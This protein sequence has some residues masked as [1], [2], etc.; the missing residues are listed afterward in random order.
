M[1]KEIKDRIVDVSF[2]VSSCV[3]FLCR[4]QRCDLFAIYVFVFFVFGMPTRRFPYRRKPSELVTHRI[5][6]VT[7]NQDGVERANLYLVQELG[8]TL[9]MV[10][11]EEEETVTV[12]ATTTHSLED[13]ATTTP[14]TTSTET[15]SR[16]YKVAIGDMQKCTCGDSEVC[17]HVLFVMI[18]L[19][20]VPA[21]NPLVWQH[22][23][24][25]REV[26]DILSGT[27]RRRAEARRRPPVRDFLR[28]SSTPSTVDGA[29]GCG[30]VERRAIEEGDTCPVC[31]DD[32]KPGAKDLTYCKKGCG[33]QAHAKC[34]KMYAEHNQ[35]VGKKVTCPL[36][37]T[38]WGPM[39][40][41]ELKKEVAGVSNHP[42]VL[43]CH[44]P[45][46]QQ[47]TGTNY[48]CITCARYDLCDRCFRGTAVHAQHQFVKRD[49][50]DAEWSPAPRV[51]RR[52]GPAALANSGRNGQRA[53]GLSASLL[54]Q[55]QD[56][57]SRR[58]F[59]SEDYELLLQLDSSVRTNSRRATMES[60][61]I[62]DDTTTVSMEEYLTDL[63]KQGGGTSGR[64]RS[65]SSSIPALS[66][67][68][69]TMCVECPGRM[70]NSGANISRLPCGHW[71]HESCAA[72]FVRR[73]AS[74]HYKCP[75]CDQ[76]AFPGLCRKRRRRR[77]PGA[78]ERIVETASAQTD[79]SDI[80]LVLEATGFTVTTGGG[81]S[82]G[83]EATSAGAR[84]RPSLVVPRG[85]RRHALPRRDNTG[86]AFSAPLGLTVRPASTAASVG[87]LGIPNPAPRCSRASSS[88]ALRRRRSHGLAIASQADTANPAGSASMPVL[89][90]S[91]AGR[92]AG[93]TP[94]PPALE[95]QAAGLTRI[96]FGRSMPL[97]SRKPKRENIPN[98]N[99]LALG[100]PIAKKRTRG[101][102]ITGLTFS[103]RKVG[104]TF[105]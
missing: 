22:A 19:L 28:R 1:L 81:A 14:P 97:K 64:S 66:S 56:I 58:E 98:N 96:S 3:P 11:H 36:C 62:Y 9:F 53:S 27:F 34:M 73:G 40:L 89:T 16:K 51:R 93:V 8:P 84:P 80:A 61:F 90:V 52:R 20:R 55:L 18:K 70:S 103:S 47:I 37:R 100:A 4:L 104:D 38:D 15:R 44:C 48:R 43:C 72:G 60:R 79:A 49:A 76:T 101:K 99:T 74:S 7:G 83:A 87:A 17:V 50:P 71:L 92:G 42:R 67:G 6:Q 54:S 10:R 59:S 31:L 25:D 75:T 23:L 65:S 30:G 63:L 85:D 102:R 57:Q 45:S 12:P 21:T 82:G 94:P 105:L 5:A 77:A 86:G 2:C 68:V 26:N 32:L 35:S 13:G 95:P 39:A 69:G 24:L 29:N 78:A 88:S 46:R 33:K 41:H 91:G